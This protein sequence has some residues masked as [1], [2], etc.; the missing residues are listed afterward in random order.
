M[1]DAARTSSARPL[2]GV[3]VI[4]AGRFVA[5]P[6]TAT[7]LAEFGADVIKV[8]RPG[9]GDELR[10]LGWLK[11]SKSL[12]WSVEARNKRSITL[13]LGHP[14]G[15]VLFRRLV[16][17]ADV[18]I[19]NFRAG[20]MEKWNLGWDDLHALNPKLI[21]LRTS[22]YGQSGP[23]RERPAFNTTAEAFGGLRYLIGEPDRAPARAGIALGD[24][25]GAIFGAIGVL[26]SL[27][28]RDANGSGA[29]QMI[30]NAL[31]EAVMRLTEY[32]IP[33]Y[34]HLGRIRER[35]GAGA[36]GTVPARA[37]RTRDDRWVALSAASDRV[38]GDLCAALEMPALAEDDRFVTN[39]RRVENVE[40]INA[41]IEE[42]MSG[43]SAEEALEKLEG[44][45][46]PG[47]LVNSAA[48]IVDDAHVAERGAL[49]TVA[50][51]E[52]GL[53]TMPGVVPRLSRTPG[54]VTHA[55]P[56]LGQHNDEVYSGLLG[57]SAPELAELRE[58][59]VI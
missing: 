11:D 35:V 12:W 4:D 5:G 20:T 22:G 16:A 55:G 8:E 45:G 18:V 25:A 26:V 14:A 3:R 58:E 27:Y 57:M 59:G 31:Y 13:D 32:T 10:R 48:D 44:N 2:E 37:F 23:Y 34:G 51:P 49:V 56:I 29:G 24:Y 33:A 50:D 7:L 28:E 17:Q 6:V 30:D 19:E 38:F 15:Q 53:T 43:L 36:S 52:L 21:M 39:A 9:S 40:A 1:S 42:W 46:V 54:Q 41:V 47:V